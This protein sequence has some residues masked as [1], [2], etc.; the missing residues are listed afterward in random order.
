MKKVPLPKLDPKKLQTGENWKPDP[1][2][3]QN[4]GNHEIPKENSREQTV[5]LAP[6]D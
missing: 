3:S 4:R 1:Q 5:P 2:D 6:P